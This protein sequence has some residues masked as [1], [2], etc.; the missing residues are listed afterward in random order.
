[1]KEGDEI[2]IIRD[3]DKPPILSD[4]TGLVA[5]ALAAGFDFKPGLDGRKTA[6]LDSTEAT[7][8]GPRREVTWA[9]DNAGS[10]TLRPI[11]KP[12]TFSLG[13]LWEKAQDRAWLDR[14]PDHPIT[15]AVAA[16]HQLLTLQRKLAMDPAKSDDPAPDPVLG[17]PLVRHDL[18][19]EGRRRYFVKRHWSKE[20]KLEE[21]AKLKKTK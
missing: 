18:I 19:R 15:L 12:Q 11:A 8:N 3:R 16:V 20:R 14:N 6:F 17:F 1:M 4:V 7:P 13:E 9:F 5:I 21:I 10:I 2:R